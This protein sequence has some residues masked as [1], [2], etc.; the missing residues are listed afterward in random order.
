MERLSELQAL[1]LLTVRKAGRVRPEDVA[2]L[3][4]EPDNQRG[5]GVVVRRLLRAGCLQA[6]WGGWGVELSYK[7]AQLL[8]GSMSRR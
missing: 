7:G 1:I 5:I 8:A 2:V 6:C 4:H 3:I